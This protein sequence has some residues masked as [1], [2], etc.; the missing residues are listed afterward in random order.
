MACYRL[1]RN[2]ATGEAVGVLECTYPSRGRKCLE[3]EFNRKKEFFHLGTEQITVAEYETYKALKLF[4]EYT[5]D[6]VT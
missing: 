4:R 6:D 1:V 5:W 2:R 3:A